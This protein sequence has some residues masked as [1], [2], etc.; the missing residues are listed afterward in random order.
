MRVLLLTEAAAAG[1]G[2]HV[3]DLAAGLERRGHEVHLLYSDRRIDAGFRSG[4]DRLHN[5]ALEKVDLKRGPHPSD[6]RGLSQ[7]RRYLQGIGGVDV[8][9]GQSS[10]G[11]ALARLVGRRAS[12][13]V[14]YTPHCVYTMNPGLGRT[15]RAFY[16]KIERWLA[17][18]SQAIIA[19]SQTEHRHLIELGIDPSILHCVV[20]GIG[21]V[22]WLDK[23]DAQ[24]KLDIPTGRTVIGA[25]GRLSEQKDPRL[26]LRAFARVHAQ[27]PR[28]ILAIA[29]SGELE[30]ECRQL[31]EQLGISAHVRWCGHQAPAAF[32]PAC[33]VFAVSSRYEAMPYVFLEALSCGLPIVATAVGGTEHAIVE[34][35]T[36]FVTEQATDEALAERLVRL[37]RDEDLRRKMSSSSRERSLEFTAD[38]MVDETLGV[39]EACIGAGVL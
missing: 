33:D 28:S 30:R 27:D 32:L 36:G 17:R 22:A 38:R 5:V 8:V 20:N 24:R 37:V 11:G 16:A 6:A 19:V 31:G 26:L 25:L 18:H 39:Y 15:K 13:A 34:G 29:G 4:C 7:I 9:H 21:E 14:V 1:V 12:A 10:K 23:G 2:R 3:V 35:E